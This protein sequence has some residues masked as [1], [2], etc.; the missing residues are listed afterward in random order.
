MDDFDVENHYKRKYPKREQKIEIT[1][2]YKNITTKQWEKRFNSLYEEGTFCDMILVADKKEFPCHRLILAATSDYF[3]CLLT[4]DFCEKDAQKIK[5]PIQSKYLKMVLDFLYKQKFVL[6]KEDVQKLY[7]AAHMLGV[8]ELYQ[9]C[10]SILTCTV[11][12]SNCLHLYFFASLYDINELQYAATT[13]I[14]ENVQDVFSNDN[15]IYLASKQ[16]EALLSLDK[17]FR[18]YNYH[19]YH[20]EERRS[21]DNVENTM[22]DLIIKWVEYDPQTRKQYL[23]EMV[24]KLNIADLDDNKLVEIS[25]HTLFQEN[26]S[27]QRTIEKVRYVNNFPNRYYFNV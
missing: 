12:K 11:D 24:E 5:M 17:V 15:V 20:G 16:V 10:A 8:E 23:N 25:R 21:Q 4:A 14:V 13:S 22:L 2:S 6:K 18:K 7:V 1:R 3:Q 19:S 27:L 9:Q 26:T